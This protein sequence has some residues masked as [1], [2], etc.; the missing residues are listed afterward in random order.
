MTKYDM[1]FDLSQGSHQ[2]AFGCFYEMLVNQSRRH[3]TRG[4]YVQGEYVQGGEYLQGR[5]YMQGRGLFTRERNI[6]KGKKLFTYVQ[7]IHY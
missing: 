4:M 5:E 2:M 1:S 7:Y 3:N 6:Y